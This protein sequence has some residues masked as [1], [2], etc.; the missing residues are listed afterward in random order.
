[1]SL[2]NRWISLLRRTA[3]GT[4]K[5]RIVLTPV[6]FVIFGTFTALFVLAGVLVDRLLG[7]PG[8]LPDAARLPVS[9]PLIAAGFFVTTWSVVHFSKVKGTP[10]PF[11]PPPKVVKTGPYR[12]IRNPM[13]GGVFLFLFGIGF[14]INS[15]SLVAFFSPLYVSINVWE[16][17]NIEEPELMKRLG[18]EYI[19]YRNQ[20]PMFIPG[21]SPGSK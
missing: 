14:A 7:L 15:I 2:R 16:L 4:R 9:L 19:E 13:L 3:T 20:T 6:G 8:L 21:R 5:T 1:M 10:V 11:N 17:K 12:Y 18:D